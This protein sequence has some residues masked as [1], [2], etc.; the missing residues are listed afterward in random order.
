MEKDNTAEQ[1]IAEGL[2]RAKFLC[3]DKTLRARELKN[4]GRKIL[5]YMCSFVPLEILTALDIVPHRI[6]GDIHAPL[7][8]VDA[9][10]E[11][12]A[13]PYV[14]HCLD[15]GL[16]QG[17][18]FLDGVIFPHSCDNVQIVSSIWNYYLKPDFYHFLDVPHMVQESSF[19]YFKTQ[20]QSLI[21]HLEEFTGKELSKTKLKEAI[22]LHN[23]NRALIRELYGLRKEAAPPI[24]GIDM[25][26]TM[27]AIQVM[28]VNE[29][30]ELIKEVIALVRARERRKVRQR[31]RLMIYGC[32]MDKPEL[33]KLIEDSGA[34]VV[35][36]D[37]CTGT[38]S[39]WDDVEIT[40]DPLDGIARRYLEKLTCSRTYRARNGTHLED[41]SNRFGYLKEYARAFKV[42]G[43]ILYII[44][45]CDTHEFDA[46]DVSDYLKSIDLS[47]L[48]IEDDY[49][50]SGME[51][52][53]TRIEAFI[54]VMA[55]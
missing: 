14:R 34:D 18:D 37:L 6:M 1:L 9:H 15:L 16:N 23:R 5:G 42:D 7:S 21:A 53:R 12:I 54:E 55:K 2:E 11:Q 46:P 40:N 41:L 19:Q 30:I 39:I 27:I 35:M 45:Y 24:N 31:P 10:L 33:I 36:D 38:K 49:T 43:V 29:Q 32:E 50:L 25:L 52:L 47:V 28:P 17:L 51:R 4:Q 3:E 22:H 13:C 48:H 26:E 20:L 8:K 44:Q